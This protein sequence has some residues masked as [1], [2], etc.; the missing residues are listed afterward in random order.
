VGLLRKGYLQDDKRR[1]VIQTTDGIE[2]GVCAVAD[3]KP[4]KTG[5]SNIGA[6]LRRGGGTFFLHSSSLVS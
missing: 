1:V 5:V 3:I 6:S 4:L 2:A